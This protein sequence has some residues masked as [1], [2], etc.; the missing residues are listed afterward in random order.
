MI[1]AM[2]EAVI[3]PVIEPVMPQVELQTFKEVLAHWS[4]GVT[5]VTT[6]QATTAVG[7]TASSFTSVSLL[8][9]R[10]LICVDHKSNTHA[11]IGKSG[12]FAVD[13]LSVEQLEW[14][15]RFADQQAAV[16][17]RFEGIDWFTAET[18]APILPGVLGWLDCRL[19]EALVCGDHTIFVGEVVTCSAAGKPSGDGEPL[20]YHHRAWRQL[21]MQSVK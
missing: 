9:P 12:Y 4:S 6:R 10:I 3:E 20:I 7:M 11:A 15:K 2:I 17:N 5:I 18:G 8:P 19:Y 16:T 14:A 21:A 13:L 1:E